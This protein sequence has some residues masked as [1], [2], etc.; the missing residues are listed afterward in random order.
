M[1]HTARSLGALGICLC[2]VSACGVH[3]PEGA[4]AVYDGGWVSADEAQQ[5]LRLMDP[6]R[7]RT[8][9]EVDSDAGTRKLLEDIAFRKIL[10]SEAGDEGPSERPLYVDDAGS[11]LVRYYIERTGKRSHEVTDEEALAYYR[12]HLEDRFTVP[13]KT[14]F[15]HIF[16][17]ADR[18]SAD[19][20]RRI[21]ARVLERL[22]AGVPFEELAASTSDSASAEDGGKVGPVYRGRLDPEFE[23]PLDSMKIGV[24]GII[25]TPAGSHIVVVLERTPPEV[26]SFEAVKRQIV[27]AIIA[28][29]DEQERE[30]LLATLRDRYGVE[31]R[32]DELGLG[33]DE[34]VIRV[35]DRT[36]TRRQLD[37]ALTSWLATPDSVS[38]GQGDRRRQFAESLITS[39]LLYL[40]A[41]DQGLRD[42][43]AFLDRLQAHELR[44]RSAVGLRQRLAKL[45]EEV[46][47]EDVLRFYDENQARF[48][49]P[50]RYH[51]R[52]LYLPF[53]SA[54]PFE[55][56][57]RL[58]R[59]AA[60]AGDV[61]E[62][63][64]DWPR[65]CNEAGVV[66][67][68][69]AGMTPLQAA[70]VG[71][72]FQRRL[73]ELD[74]PGCSGVFS[75]QMGLYAILV[76]DYEPRRALTVPDD[77]ELV[78]ARYVE[79][80]KDELVTELRRR[81]LE[82]HHFRVL[83]TDVFADRNGDG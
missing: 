56:Q 82:E 41:V 66:V 49:A 81:L 62:D 18:H 4:V 37:R 12:E 83:S 76:R 44:R 78:R 31:D 73:L 63:A 25:R 42:E 22:G 26:Q 8:D 75:D 53:G 47:D 23:G 2:T 65:R 70:R 40:D 21:E 67:T 36:M 13:E 58:E 16:L 48:K 69:M 35:K 3:A 50:P 59:L 55:L 1:S 43:D 33:P 39:N 64:D 15:Q 6:K 74:G 29:R 54:S 57:Q 5:Y 46:Q 61:S 28:R 68:E 30:Q 14:T 34:V 20:I 32:S 45:S 79:L 80:R 10:A 7:L 77:L 27:S 60:L 24:P 19:E 9:A 71:P 17:R 72:E 51:G 11:L 52:F 38:A